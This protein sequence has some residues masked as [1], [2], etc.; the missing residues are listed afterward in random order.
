L[1]AN[2][3]IDVP[4]TSLDATVGIAIQSAGVPGAEVD[5]YVFRNTVT[6]STQRSIVLYQVAGRAAI[7][8]NVITTSTILGPL[9]IA[10]GR[11]TDVIKVSGTGSYLV[12]GNS[13][14]SRWAAASG[15]RV[16]GQYAVWPIIGAVVVDNDVH[17]EAPEGTIFDDNSAGI[18]VLG[19]PSATW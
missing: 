2:N 4:G 18:D 15:I 11:G 6:N 14:H 5:A 1:I 8:R 16:Q 3:E 19:K 9:N 10:L 7:E 17:M 13:V 12:A